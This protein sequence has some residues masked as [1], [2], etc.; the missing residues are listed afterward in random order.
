MSRNEKLEDQEHII[1]AHKKIRA[2]ITQMLNVKHLD[3]QQTK[4]LRQL[5]TIEDV[6]YQY[7]TDTYIG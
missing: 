2:A 1:K 4:V 3:S 7:A 5:Y 6:L